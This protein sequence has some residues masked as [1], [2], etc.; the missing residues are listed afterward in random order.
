MKYLYPSFT[1][2]VVFFVTGTVVYGVFKYLQ[3]EELNAKK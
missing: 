1:P 2:T 3:N